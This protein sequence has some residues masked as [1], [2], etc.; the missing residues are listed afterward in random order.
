MPAFVQRKPALDRCVLMGRIIVNDQVHIELLRDILLYV[1]QELQELLM[2]VPLLALCDNLATGN[3]QGGKECRCAMPY[4]VVS[5]TFDIAE[6]HGEHGLCSIQSLD[7]ALFI[8]TEYDCI[9]WRTQIEPYNVSDFL[10][11]ERVRR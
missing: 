10:N 8:D 11:K 4:V 1:L 5:H 7:L 9:L 3:V 6:S 2:P